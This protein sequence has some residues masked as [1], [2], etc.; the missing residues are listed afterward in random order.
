[1]NAKHEAGLMGGGRPIPLEGVKIDA[2]MSGACVEVTVTQRYRNTEA[3]PVEA[4]YV[5]PL[6]EGAAVC[7]FAARIGERVIRG[8]VEEREEAFALYDDA[9]MEG[10][11]AYLLDQERP[12]VFRASVG[13]LGPGQA[14][15]LQ[16]RYVALAR[17]EGEALRLQIPTTV[18]PRYVPAGPPEV[19]EPDGE[20]VNPERWPA[21]PYGLSLGVTVSG[22]LRRVESPSHPV[23]TTL[24]DDGAR[25][26]LAQDGAALDRDFV[27]L[28]EAREPHRPIARVARE[29]DGQRVAMV[30]FLPELDEAE[31][32]GH[33]VVFLL[34]CSGSMGGESIAQAR[35]ALALCV[36]AL[37]PEDTFQIVRFGSR[38]EQLFDAPRRYDDESLARASAYVER[39]DADLGGTEILTPLRA[40]LERAPDPERPRRVLLLTDGQVSNEDQVIAHAK[41]HAGTARVFTFGIGAGASAHLVRGVA[42]ASRAATEMIYPG[43][44]IEPKVLRMFARVRTPA[45]DDVR[46]DWGGLSVEPAPGRTP[47]IFAGDALTIF[48]RITAGDASEVALRTGERRWAVPL[49]LERAEAGG[50]IP[51]LWA[52][53]RI[54]DLEEGETRRG[55]AQARAGGRDRK[56]EALVALGKRYGLTSSATSYVAIEER[57][58]D[59]R[60]DAPAQLRKIPIALTT[61][62]GGA[63]RGMSQAGSMSLPSSFGGAPPPLMRSAA[64]GGPRRRRSFAASPPPAASVP[65]A[66]EPPRPQAPAPAPFEAA[67]MDAMSFDLEGS[68]GA[69]GGAEADWVFDVLM[70]QRADGR[71]ERSGALDAQLGD[72]ASELDAAVAAH[73]EGVITAVVIALLEREAPEREAEWRPAVDKARRYLATLTLGFDAS[74][75]L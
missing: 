46:V 61:G 65:P 18:S 72:R 74:S 7:G 33:E 27:L 39:I 21:V 29:E 8:R 26:E 4:V 13:N 75:I 28:V 32:R 58:E 30:T 38:S 22:A 48:A 60:T 66:A 41:A 51:A 73:G 34:D 6:E 69:S 24:E 14:V 2:V 3:S 36:R 15:E 68:P 67:A 37:S 50:P 49:D 16:I 70:T 59:E 31:R 25:V 23:R 42:R 1:M 44:R 5:F 54:R 64:P 9:M 19:G 45:L 10:H 40:I 35:R 17:R 55:S 11:G 52:K 57:S 63:R 71:F 56:R 62:W 12:D 53:E 20:V 47:P 43:E